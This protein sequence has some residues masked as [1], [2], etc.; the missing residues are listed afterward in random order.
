MPSTPLFEFCR[1]E[2]QEQMQGCVQ[3]YHHQGLQAFHQ[4]LAGKNC[5]GYFFSQQSEHSLI[6]ASVSSPVRGFSTSVRTHC[7]I[8]AGVKPGPI[9]GIDHK[10]CR[11]PTRVF[12]QAPG[13][14][15]KQANR[16]KQAV[17]SAYQRLYKST[18]HGHPLA[19]A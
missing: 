4:H 12:L 16:Q 11:G 3:Q 9:A 15:S 10:R 2:V 6:A 14:R 13:N 5:G 7:S 18:Y 19:A 8:Q 17:G 1:E